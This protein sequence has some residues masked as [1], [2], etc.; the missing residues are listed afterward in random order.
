MK[1]K[2]EHAKAK[3]DEKKGTPINR[4]R[5]VEVKQ[6]FESLTNEGK[7]NLKKVY[8]QKTTKKSK[9]HGQPPTDLEK[10]ANAWHKKNWQ[11]QRT[12]QI[13]RVLSDF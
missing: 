3:Y 4:D 12:I 9:K 13:K 2:R 10:A 1:Y 7:M 11:M 5:K 8:S 6:E